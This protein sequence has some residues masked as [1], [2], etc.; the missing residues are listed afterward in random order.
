MTLAMT[1]L[2]CTVVRTALEPR[3]PIRAEKMVASTAPMMHRVLRPTVSVVA[4][5][6]RHPERPA[7][8]IRMLYWKDFE[9]NP[10]DV[11]KVGPYEFANCCPVVSWKKKTKERMM[12]R[13]R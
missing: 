3:E 10:I 9:P 7:T 5:A 6:I 4:T 13:L 8:A 12:V 11:K 2:F 1:T